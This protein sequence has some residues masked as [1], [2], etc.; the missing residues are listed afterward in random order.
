MIVKRPI[1]VVIYDR[2]LTLDLAKEDV[3]HMLIMPDQGSGGSW[4]RE[5]LGLPAQEASF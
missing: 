4:A 2:D 5:N 3:Y 1:G